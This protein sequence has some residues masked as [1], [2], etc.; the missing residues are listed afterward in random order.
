MADQA[1]SL[2]QLAIKAGKAQSGSFLIPSIQKG[3]AKLVVFSDKAGANLRK[4]IFNKCKSY[5]VPVIEMPMLM[6]NAISRSSSQAFAVCDAGFARNI[7]Q[8]AQR[9]HQCVLYEP[10]KD[11]NDETKTSNSK[12]EPLCSD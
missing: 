4:K 7:I 12:Q 2:V 11:Q 8:A 10:G 6:F 1:V 5:E 3:Q 9:N